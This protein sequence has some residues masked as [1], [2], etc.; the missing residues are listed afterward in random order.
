[1]KETPAPKEKHKEWYQSISFE[2]VWLHDE[3]ETAVT[4]PKSLLAQVQKEAKK[5][6]LDDFDEFCRGYHFNS[7][8][9]DDTWIEFEYKDFLELRAKTLGEK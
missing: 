5:E 1:M 6:L 9:K 4:I 3:L 7:A 8:M 2:N